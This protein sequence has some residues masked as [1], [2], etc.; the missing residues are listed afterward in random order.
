MING[1]RPH[2]PADSRLCVHLTGACLFAECGA[3]PLA[4]RIVGGQAAAPGR[5][6]WQASVALGS[7]HTCGASVLGP[8]WVV[9]AAHCTH[10]QVGGLQ[11]GRRAPPGPFLLAVGMS[12]IRCPA[13]CLPRLLRVGPG[14]FV[15]FPLFGAKHSPARMAVIIQPWV[16]RLHLVVKVLKCFP[17]H[18]LLHFL[19]FTN[20]IIKSVSM[21]FFMAFL[22]FR[23]EFPVLLPASMGAGKSL[24]YH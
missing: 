8:R 14:L 21:S 11:N 24:L 10:R 7:R 9:T 1:S 2:S 20:T 15:K 23:L 4:S 12:C 3:R 19:M 13:V 16:L 5:W 17:A 6:P 18:S 22:P